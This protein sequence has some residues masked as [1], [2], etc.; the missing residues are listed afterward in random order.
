MGRRWIGADVVSGGGTTI[1]TETIAGEVRTTDEPSARPPVSNQG[2][3]AGE[4]IPDF[5]RRTEKNESEF[6]AARETAQDLQDNN[7]RGLKELTPEL[8]E[9]GVAVGSA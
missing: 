6:R 5:L 2:V 7:G 3:E 1:V 9:G 4:P 8:C